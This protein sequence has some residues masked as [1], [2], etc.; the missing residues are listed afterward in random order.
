MA[1]SVIDVIPNTS[2]LNHDVETANFY[3]ILDATSCLLFCNERKKVQIRRC[4]PPKGNDSGKSSSVSQSWARRTAVHGQRKGNHYFTLIQLDASIENCCCSCKVLKSILKHILLI[5]H[6]VE[7][8]SGNYLFLITDYFRFVRQDITNNAMQ[9]I[10]LFHPRGKSA[11][12]V[13]SGP[14]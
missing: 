13:F 8:E 10:S 7:R 4:N 5:D 14:V 2:S 6:N 9:Q 12:C 11:T 3:D 1:V